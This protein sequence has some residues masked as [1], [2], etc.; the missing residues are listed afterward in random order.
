LQITFDTAT[1]TPR[2]AVALIALLDTVSP[3]ALLAAYDAAWED[4]AEGTATTPAHVGMPRAPVDEVTAAFGPADSL[5]PPPPPEP[6]QTA[7]GPVD[8]DGLPWDARIHATTA[9]GGG[10]L[11]ADGR[12][13]KKRGVADALVQSVTLELR[14]ALPASPICEA[15]EV[16]P[17]PVAVPMPPA[18]TSESAPPVPAASPALPVSTAPVQPPIVLFQGLMRK[19]TPLQNSGKLSV[20]EISGICQSVGVKALGDLLTK[21]D[22]IPVV[23]AQIDALAAV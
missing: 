17:P 12:W 3:G 15:D 11:T 10:S 18:Q 8:A 22:L 20:I 14:A 16:P 6:V 13:R 1:V 23:E 7:G 2:E 9:D 4:D 19:V 5:S 21:P